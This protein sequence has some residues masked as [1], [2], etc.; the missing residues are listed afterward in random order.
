MVL[1]SGRVR[2]DERL[3]GVGSTGA[4]KTDFA[5]ALAAAWVRWSATCAAMFTIPC[6]W[7]VAAVAKASLTADWNSSER[8]KAC[9]LSV[10]ARA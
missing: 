7:S 3:G 9:C 10:Q 2:L 4:F 1:P 5:F 6:A 8:R